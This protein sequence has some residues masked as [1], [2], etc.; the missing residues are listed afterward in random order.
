[1]ECWIFLFISSML[2]I[3]L[4][5]VSCCI[6]FVYTE[7]LCL[8]CFRDVFSPSSFIIKYFAEDGSPIIYRPQNHVSTQPAIV[9]SALLDANCYQTKYYFSGSA[10][11]LQWSY[12]FLDK[13]NTRGQ[14]LIV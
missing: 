5:N 6:L 9:Y 12:G 3:K 11:F 8:V 13:V 7:P 10:M 4:P 14:H 2:C 1:M